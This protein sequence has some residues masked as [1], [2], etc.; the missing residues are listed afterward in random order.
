MKILILGAGGMLGST[1]YRLLPEYGHDVYGTLRQSKK[2]QFI[3]DYFN[4]IN[5]LI[6]N[7]DVLNTDQLSQVISHLKPKVIINCIGII[8]QLDIAN[9]PLYVIPINSLLP[10]RLAELT[11]RVSARLIHISTDCVYDGK[12][13][14]YFDIFIIDF[15]NQRK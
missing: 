8:K 14:N 4:N 13:G 1:L 9:N 15:F 5:N 6:F 10:F 7:I 3:I 2:T 11:E 12:T